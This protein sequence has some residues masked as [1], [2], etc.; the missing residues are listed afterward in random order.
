[1]IFFPSAG[2]GRAIG[3][4][5]ALTVML[6]LPDAAARAQ[7]A[8]GDRPLAEMPVPVIR[9][10][11]Q[12][13]ASVAPDMAVLGLGVVRE[14]STAREALTASNEA[15]AEVIAAMKE[16]GIAARDLQ[17]TG[18]SIQ[19]RYEHPKR[20]SR[21]LEPPGIVGYTVSNQLTVRVRELG[22][23]GRIID[24]SVSLGANSSGNIAFANDD[25]SEAVARARTDAMKDAMERARTLAGAAG[26]ELGSLLEISESFNQPS[27]RPIQQTMRMEAAESVPVEGGENTYTVT[28]QASWSIRQ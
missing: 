18:F 26:V 25:P 10:S 5:S 9:V 20:D 17:T 4:A 23:L 8:G 11:G 27:P 1:M 7:P 24:R 22:D 13:Q 21:V 3:I 12:G 6:I 14:A 15:M 2:P 28:V 16:D 19:P